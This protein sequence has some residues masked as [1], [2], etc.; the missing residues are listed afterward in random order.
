MKSGSVLTASLVVLVLF[1]A[2]TK[3]GAD[4]FYKGKT[5]RFIVGAPAGSAYDTYVRAIARHLG[6]HTPGSPSMVVENMDGAGSLIAANY[7]YNKAERDGL[8]IGVWISGQV[9]RQA[10]GDRRHRFD[11]RKFGWIGAPSKGSPTCAIMVFTVFIN[12]NDV[13]HPK[14]AISMGGVREGAVYD[15][16]PTILINVAGKKFEV[17]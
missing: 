17:I 5:I 8:A 12:W 2:T 15:D 6:K 16:A 3:V 7:L 11:G 1:A 9:I 4:E 13:L 14:P 10:L